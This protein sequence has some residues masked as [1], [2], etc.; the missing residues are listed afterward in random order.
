MQDLLEK[1]LNGLETI[2]PK[3]ETIT[4]LKNSKNL[5]IKWGADP[6][7]PDLH[8][9]H[10]VVLNK[11]RLL[12][13][14]GHTVIFLIGDF[15]AMIGDPTGRSETRKPLSK[16]TILKNSQTYQD[17]VFK[18]LLKEKTQVVYNSDWLTKLP[19]NELINLTS[20]YT[21]ARMLERDD[22]EK[23]FAGQTPISIHE[24]LYPLFQG[25]DSVV[26]ENDLEIG[27]SDQ[28]FNMLLGRHLQEQYQ[29]KP[30]SIITL[31]ILEGLDGVRKMSKS[32]GNHIG[33]ME[34][35][36][37]IFGKL[38]SIPDNLIL[39][40]YRL[41]TN[42]DH[43]QLCQLE[44]KFQNNVNPKILKEDLAYFLVSKLHSESAAAKAKE[45]FKKVF[46][47]KKDPEN[48]PMINLPSKENTRLDQLILENKI[49]TSKKEFQR[50]IKDGAVSI[51]NQKITDIFFE[52]T[53]KKEQILKIG[54]LKF[55]KI[56]ST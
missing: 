10:M 34:D 36:Y 13:E 24:F 39:R 45:N 14:M 52:L 3:E 33:I 1:F 5:K 38:M 32:F 41:L 53:P 25:Y 8:L 15:T 44:L 23:R 6:S 4:K 26:L 12:Q 50:L 28:T 20:K 27:G 49:L 42:F 21:V 47:E 29:K 40:Y 18:I 9:G 30:Q 11:L 2:I 19:I 17:Q 37:Q 16:E 46:S 56:I 55:F 54:K 7:A 35:E 48:M 43:D 22:F 31:P 51:N